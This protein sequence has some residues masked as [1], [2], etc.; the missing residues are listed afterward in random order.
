[1]HSFFPT[2]D[3]TSQLPDLP[4]T[5]TL[6]LRTTNSFQKIPRIV[7]SQTPILQKI[8][9][10]IPS[11]QYSEYSPRYTVTTGVSCNGPMWVMRRYL[12][13]SLSKKLRLTHDREYRLK[14]HPVTYWFFSP[15]QTTTD[16]PSP[17]ARAKEYTQPSTRRY[18]G[19]ER[20]PTN[21][22]RTASPQMKASLIH[23]CEHTDLK[24][25]L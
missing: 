7:G 22:L 4:A 16:P 13:T 2:N 8:L 25:I 14:K 11:N 12:E 23:R 15:G 24:P 3:P 1:M 21:G 6:Q 18:H 10:K 17:L 19:P 9:H 20:K 5:N